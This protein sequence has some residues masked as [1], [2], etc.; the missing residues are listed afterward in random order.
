[1]AS[2]FLFDTSALIAH[3]RQEPGWA[4]VQALFE[5]GDS[6]I[7]VASVSLT[8][9]ARRLRE[10]GAT[11]AEARGTVEDYLEILDEVIP[12]DEGVAFTAFDIG[13]AVEKR[14]PLIDALI[15]AADHRRGACLVHRDQHMAPI[16]ADLVAQIDLSKESDEAQHLSTTQPPPLPPEPT[17]SGSPAGP[18]RRSRRQGSSGSG[19]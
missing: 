4:R 10:L 12:V 13:C 15:A 9:F 6:E 2:R 18:R 5:E 3:S 1:M 14:L 17:A 11:E 8:E 7:L 19:G 16:P